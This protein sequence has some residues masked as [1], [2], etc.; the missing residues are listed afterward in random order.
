LHKTQHEAAR[1]APFGLGGERWQEEADAGQAGRYRLNR[2][3]KLYALLATQ[4]VLWIVTLTSNNLSARDR[5]SELIVLCLSS[6]IKR[7]FVRSQIGLFRKGW[8][9]MERQRRSCCAFVMKTRK[10]VVEQAALMIEAAFFSIIVG[11]LETFQLLNPTRGT[12][13]KQL[14]KL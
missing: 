10:L 5:V 13:S 11:S 14:I 7:R 2:S 4:N 12:R 8:M 1:M 9:K 6:G 3:R